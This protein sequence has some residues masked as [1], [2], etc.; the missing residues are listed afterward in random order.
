M[1]RLLI[2]VKTTDVNHVIN[3]HDA[4]Y[5]D[6]IRMNTKQ[7]YIAGQKIMPGYFYLTKFNPDVEVFE[8]FYKNPETITIT[9]NKKEKQKLQQVILLASGLDLRKDEDYTRIE[10]ENNE[11]V[12]ISFFPLKEEV[13]NALVRAIDDETGLGDEVTEERY[14]CLF[15]EQCTDVQDGQQGRCEEIYGSY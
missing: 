5:E 6:M 15:R 2:Y 3:M 13:I 8:Q 4:Y 9:I 7:H 10:D 12:G 11:L 1:K 14:R